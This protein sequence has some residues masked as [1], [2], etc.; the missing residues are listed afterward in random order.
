MEMDKE[1]IPLSFT[2]T[3]LWA[4]K[5]IPPLMCILKTIQEMVMEKEMEMSTPINNNHPFKGQ[6]D[7]Q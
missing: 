6:Q 4:N 3:P 1:Y 2:A 5:P 7:L